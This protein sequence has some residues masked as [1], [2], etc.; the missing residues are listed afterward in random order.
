MFYFLLGSYQLKRAINDLIDVFDFLNGY[1]PNKSDENIIILK[2][3]NIHSRY[4]ILVLD[5]EKLKQMK[6]KKKKK[7]RQFNQFTE[8]CI[9]LV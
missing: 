5:V 6:L 7:N 9:F 8:W 3:V 4:Q 1:T 2:F